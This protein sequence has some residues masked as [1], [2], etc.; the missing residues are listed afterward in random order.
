MLR[1]FDFWVVYVLLCV[2]V[3]V[4]RWYLWLGS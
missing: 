1:L 2:C 4:C 3:C